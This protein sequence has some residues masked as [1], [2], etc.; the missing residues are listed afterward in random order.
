MDCILIRPSILGSFVGLSC[1]LTEN[2]TGEII[3][4]HQLLR[5]LLDKAKN[6]RKLCIIHKINDADAALADGLVI[7]APLEE[8]KLVGISDKSLEIILKIKTLKQLSLE[9]CDEITNNG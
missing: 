9:R 1:D 2:N 8:L 5:M 7:N 6:L 3:M 4:D